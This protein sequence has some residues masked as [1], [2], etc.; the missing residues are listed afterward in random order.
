MDTKPQKIS[1]I[2][3][4]NNE[5]YYRECC[6]YL[7][8]LHIPAG[9]DVDIIP[10][11]E[12]SSMAAGYETAMKQSDAKYK[13]YLH[14]DVFILNREFLS[15]TLDILTK[16]PKI[17]M[18]GMVGTKRLPDNGCMWT[19]PM[20][21][22]ALRSWCMNTVDTHFDIPM[23]DRHSFSPVQ[24]IDGLLMM[25]QYDVPWRSDLF[26]GWDFYDVSQSFEFARRGLRVA[27]PYQT[28]PWV[29]HDSGFMKLSRYH[30]YRKLF[31]QEYFP[32]NKKEI[33][34]CEEY[35]RQRE[36]SEQNRVDEVVHTIQS[37]LNQGLY[38]DACAVAKEN[39][40]SCQ[41]NEIFC[42]YTILLQ[43][44]ETECAL[45]TPE[46]FSYLSCHSADTLPQHYSNI[47]HYLWRIQY[48]LPEEYQQEGFLYF[49]K[50]H[51][52]QTAFSLILR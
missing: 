16:N 11:F 44:Y 10:V 13:I 21:T 36:I 2:I 12:A 15:D 38:Q 32:D 17:G 40:S 47:K 6:L 5:T 7:E 30:Q 34:A 48:K 20:R 25:T 14:H 4:T 19:T 31:L 23:N 43:I 37:L 52:S 50:Y 8:Q 22:G 33:D 18:L 42:I 29:L 49:D 27:V 46:I 51:V 9:F 28:A 26:D 35:I 45:G 24:A 3:C 1:F 39:L 41:K